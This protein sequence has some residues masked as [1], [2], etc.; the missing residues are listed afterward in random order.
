MAAV[1]ELHVDATTKLLLLALAD[2]A[3]ASGEAWPSYRTLAGRVGVSERQVAKLVA[4]AEA[5]GYLERQRGGRGPGDVTHYRLR[6]SPATL[7]KGVLGRP[8]GVLADQIRVSPRTLEPSV[9]R[10]IEPETNGRITQAAALHTAR[11]AIRPEIF[12]TRAKR[13]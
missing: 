12:A 6:V 10:H 11:Q 7:S 3:N 5:A 13:T 9:N 2:F 8:K 1:W 4:R